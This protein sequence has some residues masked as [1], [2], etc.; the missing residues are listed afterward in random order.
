MRVGRGANGYTRLGATGTE[1][2][3]SGAQVDF[4]HIFSDQDVAE[5]FLSRF[6]ELKANAPSAP[7]GLEGLE[8]GPTRRQAEA[9]VE[10]MNA[11]DW[12]AQG[13]T[14]EGIIL[15]FA[16]PV[17]LIQQST[18]LPPADAD[19]DGKGIWSLVDLARGPV[20]RAIPSACRIDLHD[21]ELGWVGTAWMIGPNVAVTNRHVAI[22]FASAKDGLFALTTA[23]GS[24]PKVDWRREHQ[25]PEQSRF[26]VTGVPWI[27]AEPDSDVAFLQLADE[28]DDGDALPP[29]IELMTQDEFDAAGVGRWVAVIGYPAFTGGYDTA[30][31][32]RIFDGIYEVKR[33]APGKVTMIAPSGIVGHDA[34]TL[35]GNSGSVVLDLDAGK[36]TAL[37]FGLGSQSNLAV[38]APVV[39]RIARQ[40]GIL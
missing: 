4:S 33:L 1:R 13:S 19:S 22:A 11:G 16:R 23:P 30:D 20:E 21:D 15:R 38:S 7:S 27:D 40:R 6:A 12:T 25:R 2:T 9:A 39:A 14:L 29:P 34:T 24:P 10:S 18:F 28:G 26:P 37:H 8:G 35:G 17:Y 5:E 36:A 3:P 32:Q 31:Q